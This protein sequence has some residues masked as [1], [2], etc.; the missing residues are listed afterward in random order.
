MVRGWVAAGGLSLSL[1]TSGCVE[2]LIRDFG[3]AADGGSSTTEGQMLGETEVEPGTECDQPSDCGS[4]QTCFEG[5]CVGAGTLRV[6]LSWNVV[7]DLDLHLFVPNGDWMSFENPIT[8]YGELDVDDCVAGACFNAQGPHVENIF[9]DQ[10]A[11]RGTYGIQV[12]NFDGRATADYTIEVA[13][14]VNQGFSGTLPGSEFS[15]GAT[16][17]IVW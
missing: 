1:A 16:H 11:P 9:L 14:A 8:S 5:V 13:G 4:N 12:I 17:E 2:R 15:E 10:T 6:S 7:T 3:S